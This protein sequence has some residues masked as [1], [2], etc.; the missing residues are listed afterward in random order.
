[1]WDTGGQQRYR[2]VLASC[3]RGALGVIIVFDVTNKISFK[4]IKQWMVEVE[5]FA[6]NSNIPRMLVHHLYLSKIAIPTQHHV[7]TPCIALIGVI[8]TSYH[9]IVQFCL[10]NMESLFFARKCSISIFVIFGFV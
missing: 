8:L 1:M 4:N 5:E 9:L 6:S 10:W 3:Y 7:H 2:P